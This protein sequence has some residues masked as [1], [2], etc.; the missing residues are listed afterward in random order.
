M[1]CP[2][3]STVM[4][5]DLKSKE[6]FCLKCLLSK[7]P[8]S[9][10]NVAAKEDRTYQGIV[11]DSKAEMNRYIYLKAEEKAGR[12]K[13]LVIQPKFPIV[14]TI[15]GSLICTYIADFAYHKDNKRFVEDVKS[16]KTDVYQLKKKLVKEY[17]GIDITEVK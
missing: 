3:C 2:K 15:R 14:G 1:N 5:R 7:K 17:Y 13:A 12:I 6:L 11:F 9:K 10:Y 16:V 4:H 8:R